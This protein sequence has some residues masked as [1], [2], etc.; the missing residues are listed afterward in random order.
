MKVYTYPKAK[1]L[2]FGILDI[3][4]DE[5]VI[6]KRCGCESFTIALTEK[7]RSPFAIAGIKTKATTADILRSVKDSRKIMLEQTYTTASNTA[8]R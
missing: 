7:S 3:A 2:F 8:G 1:Q 4:R 6:V 5:D